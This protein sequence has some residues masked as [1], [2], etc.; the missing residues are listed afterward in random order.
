MT[1]L[2]AELDDV[3]HSPPRFSILAMLMPAERLEFG[4]VRD[5]VELS[6]SALSQHV[7][8]LEESGFVRVIKGKVGR[9]P[10]TWL[11]ATEDGRDAFSRH[12]E[13]LNRIA[14]GAA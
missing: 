12:V 9:R 2:R 10:R 14:E 13:V 7:A 6:D 8:R 3:I 1:H 5:T 4:F 11:A